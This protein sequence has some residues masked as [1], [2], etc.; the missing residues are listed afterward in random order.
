MKPIILAI[1]DEVF[2]LNMIDLFLSNAGYLV[3]T[4]EGGGAGIDRLQ[5]MAPLPSMILL[6]LMMPDLHG[7]DVLYYIRSQPRFQHI[8]VLLQTATPNEDEIEQGLKLGASGC[9]RKPYTVPQLLHNI[10]QIMPAPKVE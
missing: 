6:D 10:A 4:I 9:I 1:D 7:L 8:P 5:N 2:Y 3:I